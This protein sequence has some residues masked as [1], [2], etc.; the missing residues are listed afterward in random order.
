MPTWRE[1]VLSA[2]RH[3]VAQ[4]GSVLMTRQAFIAEMLPRIV[5]AT[6]SHGRTPEQTLSR[7]LQELRDDGLLEFLGEGRYLFLG[8]P[9]AVQDE[10]LPDEALDH[11]IEADRLTIPN[12]ATVSD[13]VQRARV[14]RGQDRLRTLTLANYG[15]QC[16]FCD[17]RDTTL[18]V[19]AHIVRWAD[20]P[21]WRGS[22]HNTMAMCRFHDPLFEHGYFGLNANFDIVRRPL[23]PEAGSLAQMILDATTTFHPPRQHAPDPRFLAMHCQRHNLA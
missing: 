22:L 6:G 7:V 18:L 12:E 23:P 15:W 5:A 8:D 9:I 17:V 13:T 2:L 20:A 1:S 10:D 11:A 14:R 21:Q 19:A 16:A 3:Y 4:H